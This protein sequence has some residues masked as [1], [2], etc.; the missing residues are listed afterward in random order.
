MHIG[1]Y[2]GSFNPIHIG[3]LIVA[4]HV[5]EYT[6]IDKVWFVVSPH[7]PLK[8]SHSLLNEHDRLHLV[9]IAIEG[10][11][12]F[13]ASSVEFQLPKP[14]Y[15]IDTLAYLTEKFP[16]EKFSVIMGADS[17]QNIHRWKNFEQL[18]E[19]HSFIVYNRPG[20]EIED[21]YGA[22]IK[23]LEAPLLQISSTY[24]RR[25]IKDKK[26]IKYIVPPAVEQYIIDNRYYAK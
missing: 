26:S 1:L 23:K 11:P 15:T 9:N 13:R 19:R 12:K 14:S 2:F 8:D 18:V 25:Q 3:H 4:N 17:F 21:T 10:N 6:D 22:N 5:I 24:I 7:N 16:L 20:F